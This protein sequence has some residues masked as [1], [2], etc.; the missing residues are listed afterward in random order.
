[1]IY[2]F[3]IDDN[4]IASITQFEL[5]N[6]E[7]YKRIDEQVHTMSLADVRLTIEGWNIMFKD[8]K[9]TTGETLMEL[10]NKFETLIQTKTI[11]YI[12]WWYYQYHDV[13]IAV[14]TV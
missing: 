10:W 9:S 4:S 3:R 14:E 8:V 13:N 7:W 12:K 6:S 1:M 11:K 5:T 2:N